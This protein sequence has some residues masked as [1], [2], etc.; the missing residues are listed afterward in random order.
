MKS[1][2][3][4]ASEINGPFGLVVPLVGGVFSIAY[5]QFLRAGSL[6]MFEGFGL[7]NRRFWGRVTELI[8]YGL[9]ALSVTDGAM[10]VARWAC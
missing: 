2:I 9:V 10:M 7:R 4:A 1:H 8:G 6:G 3:V 5:G